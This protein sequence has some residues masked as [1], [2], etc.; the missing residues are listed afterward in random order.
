MHAAAATC[1]RSSPCSSP[2][3]GGRRRPACRR[4]HLLALLALLLS[5]LLGWALKRYRASRPLLVTN[6]VGVVLPLLSPALHLKNV[7]AMLLSPAA[8]RTEVR[9]AAWGARR[10]FTPLHAFTDVAPPPAPDYARDDTAWA[11]LWPRWDTADLTSANWVDVV[12]RDNDDNSADRDN[13]DQDDAPCDLFYLHP[14][15]FFSADGWN[16]N[17]D[18]HGAALMVDE[19]IMFQQASAFVG[20]CRVWA[21][22][23]RQ[24]TA[25]GYFDPQENGA[26][27]LDL[28]YTDVKRAF[29]EF[30]RRRRRESGSGSS[31]R[32]ILLA[33]H[34]QGTTLM[35]RLLLEE[36]AADTAE[37]A[38]LRALLV[39]AYLLGMEIRDGP[40]SHGAKPD[41][42]RVADE[43]AARA[44]GRVMLPLCERW[45]QVGCVVA[46]RTFF[47]DTNT[48]DVCASF[49]GRPPFPG[50]RRTEALPP[51]RVVCTNPLTW[52]A[53]GQQGD[54]EPLP[55][56]GC[57]P[58]IHPHANVHYLLHGQGANETSADRLKGKVS[59]VDMN[60]RIR[61]ARCDAGGALR[62]DMPLAQRMW[63]SGWWVPFPAWTVF[64]FPGQN[65]HAYDYNLFF[66]NLRQNGAQRTRAWLT[67]RDEATDL[68]HA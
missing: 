12:H 47:G 63:A 38:R 1:S 66:N 55:H 41:A 59:D 11:A 22:R 25:A 21:P 40:Y 14:T 23:F 32:P 67:A 26:R 49:L 37:G 58:I 60:C 48:P 33:S 50:T 42:A 62:L 7:V 36:F 24:M 4:R 2:S 13:F 17:F 31:R 51:Q 61:S 3:M 64:S 16:A 57:M 20:T 65:E 19:G 68:T 53:M 52:T 6:L 46:F 8:A 10:L 45:E 39:A 9:I 44:S 29:A 27:A 35:E 15:T 43:A 54:D 5:L 30:L 34:S 18:N 28:A 56:L